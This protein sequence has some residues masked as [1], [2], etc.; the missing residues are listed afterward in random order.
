MKLAPKERI[1]NLANLGRGAVAKGIGLKAVNEERHDGP[2]KDVI[3]VLYPGKCQL[4]GRDCKCGS[5]PQSTSWARSA[6]CLVLDG[7][8]GRALV[9]KYMYLRGMGQSRLLQRGARTNLGY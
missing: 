6:R 5:L 9:T 1:V 4:V 2:K 8:S 3:T 7:R